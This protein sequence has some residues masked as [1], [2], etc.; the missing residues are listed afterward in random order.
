MSIDD[1]TI[2]FRGEEGSPQTLVEV[3]GGLQVPKDSADSGLLLTPLHL[4]SQRTL[5]SESAM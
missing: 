3:I 2:E 4:L 1:A 5:V